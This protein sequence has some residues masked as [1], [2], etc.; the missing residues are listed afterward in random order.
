M[1]L[2]REV[3][4]SPASTTS[5]IKDKQIDILTNDLRRSIERLDKVIGKS[6]N[7]L[8]SGFTLKN[9][10]AVVNRQ[11]ANLYLATP[12]GSNKKIIEAPKKLLGTKPIPAMRIEDPY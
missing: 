10:A 8:N 12:Q 6:Q 4:K 9:K 5:G 1:T 7:V 11:G 2:K 3:Q